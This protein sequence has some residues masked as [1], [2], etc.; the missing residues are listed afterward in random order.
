[1]KCSNVQ[2]INENVT[3]NPSFFLKNTNILRNCDFVR[4]SFMV[5]PLQKH[6]YSKPHIW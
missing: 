4:T 6:R 5:G 2:A 3:F 1:M